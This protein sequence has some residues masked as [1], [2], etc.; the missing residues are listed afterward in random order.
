MKGTFLLN[1]GWPLLR[2]HQVGKTRWENRKKDGNRKME[3]KSLIWR[4]SKLSKKE[5]CGTKAPL[6]SCMVQRK[7][8][9]DQYGWVDEKK[10]DTWERNKG[11]RFLNAEEDNL[12]REKRWWELGKIGIGEDMVAKHLQKTEAKGCVMC[13]NNLNLSCI[14]I[15]IKPCLFLLLAP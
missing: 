1:A 7:R 12:K 3:G 9:V 8:I 4:P 6:I 5:F 13:D 11:P 2:S 10:W 15:P 14:R